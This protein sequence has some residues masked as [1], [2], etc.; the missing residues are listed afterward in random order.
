M[1][2]YTR[3][4]CVECGGPI[5]KKFGEYL[6]EYN[7]RIYCRKECIAAWQK[8]HLETVRER[9]GNEVDRS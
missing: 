9:N 2:P 3:N 4:K 1:R 8:K 5:T 7:K 6:E